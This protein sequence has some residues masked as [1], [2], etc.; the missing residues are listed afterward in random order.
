[1]CLIAIKSL[2]FVELSLL[3]QTL[4]PFAQQSTEEIRRSTNTVLTGEFKDSAEF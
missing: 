1:M 3:L 4:E 2:T